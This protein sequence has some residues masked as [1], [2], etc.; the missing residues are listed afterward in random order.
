MSNR[1]HKHRERTVL[2]YPFLFHPPAAHHHID[3]HSHI[4]HLDCLLNRQQQTNNHSM[5]FGVSLLFI[6]SSTSKID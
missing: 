4:L 2:F 6:S 3:V 1:I 5:S